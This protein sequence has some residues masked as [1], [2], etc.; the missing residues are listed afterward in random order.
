M[1]NEMSK[2]QAA[3]LVKHLIKDLIEE[4][5]IIEAGWLGLASVAYKDA[6]EKQYEMLRQAFFAGAQHLFASIMTTLEPGE[7]TEADL[8]RIHAINEELEKFIE[9]FKLQHL[10]P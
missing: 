10:T 9:D 8:S 6:T 5:L 3:K 7:V 4:G 2:E 1:E